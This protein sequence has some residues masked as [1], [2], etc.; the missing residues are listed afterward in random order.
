MSEPA[1]NSQN[2]DPRARISSRS[3]GQLAQFVTSELGIKMP[4]SKVSLI[5]SRLLHRV[6]DLGLASIDGWLVAQCFRSPGSSWS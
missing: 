5:Q 3:F 2:I 4:E 1:G 6:R